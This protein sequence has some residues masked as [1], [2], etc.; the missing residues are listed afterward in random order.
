MSTVITI[1]GG[2]LA[3]SEAAWQ[4]AERGVCVTLYEMRPHK[5]TPA[6]VSDWLAELVCSNSL[7]S[8]LPDR[9]A[10]LLKNELRYL[11]SLVLACADRARVPAGGALAVDRELFAAEVT[12]RVEAHPRIS[13]VREE[14]TAIP[15]GPAVISTGPLTSDPLAEAIAALT[16]QEHLYFYDALA[17][18]VAADSVDMSVAFRASRYGKGDA[19]YI[20]CPLTEEEYVRFVKE[21][22]AAERIPLHEFEQEPDR[23][24]EG[25]LAVEV[26]AARG[27][28][29][30]AFGP[31]RP[32]GLTDP[33]TGK[34]PYAVVQLRQDNLAGTLY[35]LVGF[36]TN[37]RYGEQERVFRLI[38]GLERAEFVRFGHMHRNT[39]INAPLF[40]EATMEFRA[41]PGLFFAGQ[42][43]GVEGYVGSVGSGWV[44][45][46]NVAR[47][48]LGQEP[49]V[50]P[51][52]TM[53][54]ALCHYASH[55]EPKSF[56]PMKANFGLMPPLS[57]PVRN[58]Q[59]RYQAYAERAM[60]NLKSQFPISKSQT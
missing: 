7:G 39:F 33:R 10:G 60:S 17:P 52:A 6:H 51:R 15:A 22:G 35:N 48:V 23:F 26:M 3:G 43:T 28:D 56:Q 32:V 24:F 27:R 5:T 30:L 49:L 50:L 9:A 59:K 55:A 16:G 54:G 4:A 41:R 1:V 45:G 13:V 11:R 36:Q 31:L 37:L 25:C 19:D 38:P 34:R 29:T 12:R 44:A 2:G 57:P 8:D 14:A 21:L 20:N 58:K 42:I 46:V 18:I 53:L 40:L 47:S